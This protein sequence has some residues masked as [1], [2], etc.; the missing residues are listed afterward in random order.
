MSQYIAIEHLSIY[1][2][3]TV[4]VEDLSL[5]LEQGE[6]LTILGETG[7]GKIAARRADDGWFKQHCPS[8]GRHR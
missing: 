8:R 2:Q 4:I 5:N 7:A 1:A 3:D 6:T